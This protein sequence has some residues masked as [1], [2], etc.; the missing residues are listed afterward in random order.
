[1]YELVILACL[2][3][4]PERCDSFTVPLEGGGGARECMHAGEIQLTRFIQEKPGWVV[5]RWRCAVTPA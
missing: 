2:I 3:A 5:R 4:H 1:M